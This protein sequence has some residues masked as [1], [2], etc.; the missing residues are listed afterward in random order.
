MTVPDETV[1]DETVPEETGPDKTG[2]DETVP[3]AQYAA[4]AAIR[5]RVLGAERADRPPSEFGAPFREYVVRG[6]WAQVW[7]RPGLDLRTRSCV[8]VAILA[9]LH[10][11][12]ELDMHVE[13]ALRNGVS[14]DELAEV[15][16]HVA[17]Y[18]GAPAGN[19]AFAIAE[20]VLDRTTERPA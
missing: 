7:A 20:R 5:R 6:A 3:D 14:P 16:L 8:T 19:A 4:G 17:V 13:A 15:L 11:D 10:C 1:P 9:A 2:S 18:A 12:E